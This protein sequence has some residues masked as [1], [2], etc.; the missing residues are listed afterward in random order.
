M[1]TEARFSCTFK[2]FNTESAVEQFTVRGDEFEEFRQNYALLKQMLT[3][4]QFTWREPDKNAQG[5]TERIVGYVVSETKNREVCVHLYKRGL[6][7]RSYTLYPEDRH[8]LPAAWPTR[9]EWMGTAPEMEDA[10]ERNVFHP[11]EFDLPVVPVTDYDGNIVYNDDGRIKYK[12]DREA[13]GAGVNGAPTA[14]AAAPNGASAPQANQALRSTVQYAH[15]RKLPDVEKYSAAQIGDD[16]ANEP[17][18]EYWWGGL[19]ASE[20]DVLMYA[21]TFIATYKRAPV[22]DNGLKIWNAITEQMAQKTGFLDA[23]SVCAYTH[24]LLTNIPFEPDYAPAT[25]VVQWLAECAMKNKADGS[26]N[27]HYDPEWMD[28]FTAIVVKAYRYDND[29]DDEIESLSD[30][31]EF[32]F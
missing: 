24:W 28:A 11:L 27:P 31:T 8:L 13:K 3:Q 9:A 17:I 22:T 7:W 14:K 32:P 21:R 18:N 29:S 2:V 12:P 23:R 30:V 5:K 6:K 16:S 4:E 26:V 20:Q 15:K 19:N 10:K 1:T 25:G